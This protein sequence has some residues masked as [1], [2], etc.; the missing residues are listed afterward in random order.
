MI[1]VVFILAGSFE[2]ALHALISLVKMSAVNFSSFWQ[3]TSTFLSGFTVVCLI[4]CP[5]YVWSH[6]GILSRTE[7]EDLTDDIRRRYGEIFAGLKKRS[8]WALNY[9]TFFLLRRYIL[10]TA[11][12]ALYDRKFQLVQINV[13]ILMSLMFQVYLLYHRPY[14]H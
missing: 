12:V 4:V 10:V 13:A 3:I 14:K 1:A 8:N 11:T 2:L 6:A 9:Q 7:T 5:L